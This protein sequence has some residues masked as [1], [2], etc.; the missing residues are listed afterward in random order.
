MRLSARHIAALAA[1]VIAVASTAQA[2][3]SEFIVSA[4]VVSDEAA[5]LPVPESPSDEVAH[6][7]DQEQP[8]SSACSSCM[9][10][11]GRRLLGSR[12]GGCNGLG[13]CNGSCG[14]VGRTYGS[15]D[16]FYNYYT[17]GNC[18]QTNAQMY[19]SP[20]PVPA[21]VGHTFYTYQPFNPHEMLYW[22]KD[23]YHNY[24]DCGRGMNRTRAM[25]YSPPVRQA[26][27]NV[28]WNYLR[29]PR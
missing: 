22:H 11:G 27:S 26:I 8:S 20:V 10:N 29:L 15:P 21:N 16:L 24:Y 7:G 17:Q 6:V 2:Q 3:Q 28:Y 18:N 19:L 14:C 25:Y 4:R 12:M 5:E 13:A 23:R 9:S 1:S